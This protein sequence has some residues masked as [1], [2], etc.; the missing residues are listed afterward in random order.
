MLNGRKLQD[1]SREVHV[2]I[3]CTSVF[4]ARLQNLQ[5]PQ[6]VRQVLT[7]CWME[8]RPPQK[9]IQYFWTVAHLVWL[10]TPTL[11]FFQEMIPLSSDAADKTLHV[12]PG[13]AMKE[14]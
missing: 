11:F 12:I 10:L 8:Q 1:Q 5:K 4:P 9:L 13:Q 7:T 2:G 6:L 14:T 3:Q